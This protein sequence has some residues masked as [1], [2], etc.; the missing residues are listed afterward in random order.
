M[1]VLARNK[2]AT[3]DYDL[4]RE[5]E[6]GLA[7]TGAEVKAVRAGHVQLKGSYLT[8]NNNELFLKQAFI[9]PYAPA[10]PQ[11]GYDPYRMRKVLINANELAYIKEKK[12]AEGLTIIPISVY[13][14]GNFLKLG[15]AVARGKKKYEKRESIKKRDI[16]RQIRSALKR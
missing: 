4:I 6:G 2:K 10:G 7:L 1:S 5:M 9:G 16:D 12:N 15:F 14:K 13:T 11:E 8:V 3:F